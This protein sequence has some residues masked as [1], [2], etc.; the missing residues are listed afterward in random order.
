MAKHSPRP[1]LN[2]HSTRKSGNTHPRFDSLASRRP[3]IRRAIATGVDTLANST[4]KALALAV[5][6]L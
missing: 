6:S 3:A 1:P 5:A 4:S 2:P